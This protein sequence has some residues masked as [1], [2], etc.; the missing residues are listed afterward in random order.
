M[1]FQI[2]RRNILISGTRALHIR[3][4][5]DGCCPGLVKVKILQKIFACNTFVKISG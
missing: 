4:G 3:K 1:F 2:V 5:A